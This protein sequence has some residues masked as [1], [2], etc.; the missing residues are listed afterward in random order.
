MPF[1]SFVRPITWSVVS[2][3]LLLLSACKPY[4]LPI[5]GSE[6]TSLEKIQ[7]RGHIRM[8]TINDSL[9]Y[10][11]DG[12]VYSGFDYQLGKQFADDLKVKFTVKEYPTYE[13]LFRALDNDEVDF[14]GAGLT[15]TPKRAQKYRSSPPYYYVSQKVVYHKNTYRPRQIEDINAPVSVL[16]G[17]SH[18]ETLE[19]LSEKVKDFK[20]NVL[21]NQNPDT[22]LR[23]IAEKEITFAIVD[24]STLAQKQRYYPVLTE[25]FTI[26]DKQPVAWLLKRLPDDTL[27]AA[28][29][30]FMGHRYADNSIAKL[31]E[32]YFGH[33]RRFDFVD[34]IVFM[35]RNKSILPK[36]EPLFKKY[37]TSEVDWLLLAAVSYQESHWNPKAKSPTGVRGMMMLT[38]D[39]ADYIGIKDRLDVEQSIKGGANYLTQLINRLPESIPENQRIWFALAS[40]NLGYGHVIDAR[41][42]T[43]MRKQNPD[44]WSDV[45][46]NLPLLHEKKWYSKTKYGY[47]RGREAKHYVNNIRQYLKSLTWF[48]TA[49]NEQLAEQKALQ[50]AS[51]K[52][53]AE[54]VALAKQQA[55]AKAQALQTP[56]TKEAA[57]AQAKIITL[58]KETAL[59]KAKETTLAIGNALQQAKEKALAEEDSL[60]QAKQKT[61]TEEN[62]L[63]QAKEKTLT[64]EQA[65]QRAKDVALAKEKQLQETKEKALAQQIILQ[66]AKDNAFAEQQSVQQAKDKAIAKQQSAQQAKDN[67]VS[68]QQRLQ[69]PS[70][71]EISQEDKEGLQL[72]GEEKA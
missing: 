40:Y 41:R 35:K 65:L 37:A 21:E 22:L 72:E 56:L 30:E 4:F 45:K 63:Q 64:I 60:Q 52:A 59:Q 32:K 14:L 5:T 66:K 11:F 3:I 13:T 23:K 70:E 61:L 38:L 8:G 68:E 26:A 17:S 43:A 67:A 7:K 69:Q 12:D 48:I 55:L 16:K 53:L 47:A 31:E 19:Y 24:S 1:K 27:Y 25:A 39:T 10:S 71:Q 34:T 50:E 2:F 46:E 62:A 20:I 57:L 54:K 36:F 6:D 51:D 58:E 28:V 18:Q 29:I 49:R 33:V 42:I 9:T 15:L 44:A